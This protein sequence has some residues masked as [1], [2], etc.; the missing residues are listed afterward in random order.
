MKMHH[1]TIQTFELSSCGAGLRRTRQTQRWNRP[2]NITMFVMQSWWASLFKRFSAIQKSSDSWKLVVYGPLMIR[3]SMQLF[4]A[5]RDICQ[6]LWPSS[7]LP[8]PSRHAMQVPSI[9]EVTQNTLISD[10][11]KQSVWTAGTVKS[12]L[13]HISN[14]L[15]IGFRS[16]LQISDFMWFFAVQTEYSQCGSNLDRSDI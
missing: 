10:F 2:V 14:H 9:C 11:N 16:D 13:N 12:D 1:L 8:C 3:G 7:T 4:N 6:A 5:L 15:T